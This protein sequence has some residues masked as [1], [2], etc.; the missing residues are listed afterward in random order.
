MTGSAGPRGDIAVRRDF[1]RAVLHVG[2]DDGRVVEI[3]AGLNDTERVILGRP[4]GLSNGDPI[5]T[6]SQ[7]D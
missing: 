6:G 5:G 7:S 3:L 4:A 2:L 1:D